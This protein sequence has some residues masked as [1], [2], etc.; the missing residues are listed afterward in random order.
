MIVGTIS[1]FGVYKYNKAFADDKQ[2]VKESLSSTKLFS[3]GL[4]C[5]N[6]SIFQACPS[7]V[8]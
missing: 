5:L 8:V 4:T 1:F 3:Q 7:K 6:E 2:C